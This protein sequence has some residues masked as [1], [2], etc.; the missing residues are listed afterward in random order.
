MLWSKNDTRTAE[1]A[2]S[3]LNPIAVS[4]REGVPVSAS[5]ALPEATDAQGDMFGTDRMLV[6]LNEAVDGTPEAVLTQVR[7]G[8]DAFVKNAEQF[9]DLTMLCLEYKGG[10]G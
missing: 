9:D 10:Q 4:T 5:Q 8:V 3:R 7:R 6:S 2:S 1:Y